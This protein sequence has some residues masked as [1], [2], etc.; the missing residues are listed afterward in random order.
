MYESFVASD[1]VYGSIVCTS[2]AVGQ[3][4]KLEKWN[5]RAIRLVCND[6]VNAFDN[7]LK[8]KKKPGLTD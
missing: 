3:D 1:C 6:Y 2:F 4:K 5:E 8:K 7:I